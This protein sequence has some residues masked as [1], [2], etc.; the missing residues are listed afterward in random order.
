M[1]LSLAL[2][3]FLLSYSIQLRYICMFELVLEF[4]ILVWIKHFMVQI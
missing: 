1:L 4:T 3:E 2:I